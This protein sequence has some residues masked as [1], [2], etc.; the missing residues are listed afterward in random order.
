MINILITYTLKVMMNFN[1]YTE[2]I[3]ALFFITKI[4]FVSMSVAK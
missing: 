1:N 4:G 3:P 2:P